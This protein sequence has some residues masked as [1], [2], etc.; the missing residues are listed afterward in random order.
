MEPALTDGPPEERRRFLNNTLSQ[1]HPGYL[2]DLI[3]YRRTMKQRNAVLAQ[4]RFAAAGLLEPW[5]EELSTGAARITLARLTFIE[6]FNRF[7]AR[8]YTLMDTIAETPSIEYKGFDTFEPGSDLPDVLARYKTRL[9]RSIPR[10][11]ELRRSLLGPHRDDLVFRLDDL[12]VRR[13]ASQ[14]QHRSFGMAL[15]LAK[16][17]YLRSISDEKPIL[18]L[19]DVFGD[20]DRDRSTVFL[21]LL[22]RSDD[23]GQSIITGAD[24]GPFRQSID[25]TKP[26]HSSYMIA[27][28]STT[29]ASV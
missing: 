24:E 29:Q 12:E 2:A 1:A 8:A 5:N 6:E 7:M 22:E 26:D 25:F 18:L 10:E 19:D 11:R 20:L 16:F 17:L 14:G 9:S 21:R 15:K 23:L 28:G 4:G 13:Y 3:K 27:N